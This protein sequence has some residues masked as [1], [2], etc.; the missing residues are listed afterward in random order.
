MLGIARR[1]SELL[2]KEIEGLREEAKQQSVYY[3]KKLSKEM[4]K[5]K[6]KED[7]VIELKAMITELKNMKATSDQNMS[8]IKKESE[9]IENLRERHQEEIS[10]MRKDYEAS[11]KE[12]R[13][14]HQKDKDILESKVKKLEDR[15]KKNSPE[16]QAAQ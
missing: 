13:G 5:S 11:L 12:I 4:G 10:K 6:E 7:E 16:T 2:K 14:V 15:L 1:E 3:N 8:K 9:A